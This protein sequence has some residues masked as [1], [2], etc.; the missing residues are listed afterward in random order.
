[1]LAECL[2]VR[3]SVPN[4]T[5]WPS[6][7]WLRRLLSM[8]ATG[9][10]GIG[11]FGRLID[12]EKKVCVCERTKTLRLKQHLQNHRKDHQYNVS[13]LIQKPLEQHKRISWS[14]QKVTKRIALRLTQPIPSLR[15]PPDANTLCFSIHCRSH[16]TAPPHLTRT[17]HMLY[18]HT[19]IS[20]NCYNLVVRLHDRLS[21][22]FHLRKL[23]ARVRMIDELA[24]MDERSDG[25]LHVDARLS[26]AREQAP[27]F[28]N[29]LVACNVELLIRRKTS[30]CV[31]II[32]LL[33]QTQRVAILRP[34]PGRP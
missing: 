8:Q 33:W 12:L 25:R 10:M 19:Y 9:S 32:T 24:C 5:A 1:M 18:R 17:M 31:I 22:V 4:A 21:E 16:M 27:V 23:G 26:V 11:I 7:L 6:W 34:M 28:F 14:F 15:N 13:N 20:S 2:V 29:E 3:L 30:R